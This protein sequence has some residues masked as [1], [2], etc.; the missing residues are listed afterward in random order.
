MGRRRLLYQGTEVLP[1]RFADVVRECETTW[2]SF[3]TREHAQ[4][5]RIA[6]RLVGKPRQRKKEVGEL[7]GRYPAQLCT[8]LD[9]WR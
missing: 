4:A 5:E 6:A 7:Q 1:S 3:H 2:G 8:V 9:L